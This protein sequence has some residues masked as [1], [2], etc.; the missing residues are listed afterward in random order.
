MVVPS[1]LPGAG[2]GAPPTPRKEF[3]SEN[4][5]A[6]S[7]E[8]RWSHQKAERIISCWM[9][10]EDRWTTGDLRSAAPTFSPK[11]PTDWGFQLAAPQ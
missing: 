3:G 2:R 9:P 7:R 11:S 5:E 4:S 6:R 8:G 10:V 1:S